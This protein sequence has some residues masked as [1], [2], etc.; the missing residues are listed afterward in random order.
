MSDD[1]SAAPG[2]PIISFDNPKAPPTILAIG[3]V[4]LRAIAWWEDVDFILSIREEKVAMTLQLFLDWG[5]LV[6]M[7][8]GV[9]W[10]LGAHKTL[11]DT[12]TVHWGMV[13]AIGILAFMAGALITVHAIGSMPTVLTAWGGDAIAQNCSAVVDTTRLVGL[14][15]KDRIVLLCGIADP[16]HD[17]M[18]D[19]KIAVSQ[20]FTIT[21][22]ATPIVAPYGAMAEAVKQLENSANS[23]LKIPNQNAGFMMWHSVAVI[24]RELNTSEIKRASDVAKRGG[25]IVTEPQVGAFGNLQAIIP[26]IQ[27][28]GKL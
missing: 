17:A 23:T 6:L 4:L 12:T 3:A 27:P 16:S 8:V 1:I 28:T 9:I 13:T 10:A 5:W 2:K 24:P 18:E 21:G 11:K 14:K 22:H 26:I 19:E 25:K 15:D 20:P 7:I